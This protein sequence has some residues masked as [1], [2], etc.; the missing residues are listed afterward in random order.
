MNKN[1]KLLIA[2]ATL[3]L[4]LTACKED[5]FDQEAYDA[6]IMKAFPVKNVSPNQTWATFGT[7]TATVTV[8]GDLGGRYRVAVYKSNPEYTAPV[9]LLADDRINSGG[10]TT[11]PFSFELAHPTVYVACFDSKN[12]RVVRPLN[13]ENEGSYTIDFFG[14]DSS[15]KARA[16][17]M[18]RLF[19]PFTAMTSGA[20]RTW[21]TRAGYAVDIYTN[22]N[23]TV[24]LGW[25]DGNAV[26][27]PTLDDA[28]KNAIQENYYL[29]VDFT[30]EPYVDNANERYYQLFVMGTWWTK[31]TGIQSASGYV[32]ENGNTYIALDAA[33]TNVEFRLTAADLDILKQQGLFLAG[34][35]IY[36]RRVYISEESQASGGGGGNEQGNENGNEN[37]DEDV[38]TLDFDPVL[39]PRDFTISN[40]NLTD[41]T[42]N[43]YVL[44]REAQKSLNDY[45]V[46][47]SNFNH[48]TLSLD[49]NSTSYLYNQMT[50]NMDFNTV[51]GDNRNLRYWHVASGVEIN[52]A[53]SLYCRDQNMLNTAVLYVEGTVHLKQ[54]STLSGVTII[55]ANGGHV[56]VES[57]DVSITGPTHFVVQQGGTLTVNKDITLNLQQ[58]EDAR[59]LYNAGTLDVKGKIDMGD[60][61][62]SFFYNVGNATVNYFKG[63]RIYNYGDLSAATVLLNRT[64]TSQ[65][66]YEFYNQGNCYIKTSTMGRAVNYGTFNGETLDISDNIYFNGG[67]STFDTINVKWLYNYGQLTAET[68]E[69]TNDRLTVNAC[70]LHYTGSL[71]E[72]TGF[73]N[74]IMMKNSRLT[75]DGTMWMKDTG[76]SDDFSIATGSMIECSTLRSNDDIKF[77]GPTGNGEFCV[78]KIG[79]ILPA[80]EQAADDGFIQ[81]K[82]WS[83]FKTSGNVYFEWSKIADA[84]NNCSFGVMDPEG[85]NAA[86]AE[87]LI[88]QFPYTITETTAPAQIIIPADTGENGCTGPG[89]N[90]NPT[91]VV[92]QPQEETIGF[93]F[94]FEDYFPSPGD[95]DFNDCVITVNATRSGTTVTLRISL[96]AV[97]AT[98]QIAA[99]LNLVGISPSSIV[100]ATTD[101]NDI[102]G[103]ERYQAYA[104]IR[105][106]E[107]TWGTD[108]R[109]VITDEGSYGLKFDKVTKDY[110]QYTDPH[111]IISLFNDA[112]WCISRENE[113]AYPTELHKRFFNTIPNSLDHP[114]ADN[115]KTPRVMTYTFELDTEDNAKRFLTEDIYDLFIVERYDSRDWEV[116]TYPYKFDQVLPSLGIA[117]EKLSAYI[118]GKSEAYPWSI[119][120]PST[121]KYPVEWQSIGSSIYVDGDS[122]E[123]SNAA[124]EY[125]STWAEDPYNT[126]F[127][128][129][130][131]TPVSS[132]RVFNDVPQ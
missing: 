111:T 49:Y 48:E 57:N 15:A 103:N 58:N 75:I 3:S 77:Y 23:P 41:Q 90:G 87:K 56:I 74:L 122:Y 84:A 99:A 117:T 13:V 35:G 11:L 51:S 96:D 79:N 45:F 53:F 19:Q 6:R 25:D 73:K 109:R 18:P 127:R 83:D 66:L 60:G 68:N 64:Q 107:K 70:Y 47:P 63:R 114:Y 105:G 116:H 91:T 38:P 55:V 10:T 113:G 81:C 21:S 94:C 102:I 62:G 67:S 119:M 126:A 42:Y 50:A 115:T 78:V 4:G 1:A 121:F 76:S 16:F 61:D 46:N 59:G 98:K 101:Y 44:Q 110:L 86:N 108:V 34:H 54:W 8:N 5:Y 26:K 130:Y 71:T 82:K 65:S 43:A 40:T 2:L 7:A 20:R 30:C 28:V 80:N 52:N 22:D 24:P 33:S 120:V 123:S 14:E 93:R 124:Y 104:K 29:G 69:K 118:G 97:G 89:Y 32:E 112:H 132:D 95:Y 100:S 92:E 39:T 128:S 36:V 72:D 131:E 27:V 129:W 106:Y 37:P 31:L 17:N 85:D 125:F 9:V 88:G 12:R